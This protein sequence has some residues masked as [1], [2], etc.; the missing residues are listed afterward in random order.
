MTVT[1]TFFQC[2]SF[3]TWGKDWNIDAHGRGF[4]FKY[5]FN[6]V[7]GCFFFYPN[8]VLVSLLKQAATEN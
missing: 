1:I 8:C 2:H 5:R 3:A 7:R 6:V 4:P